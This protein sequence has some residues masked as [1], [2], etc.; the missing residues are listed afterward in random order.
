MKTLFVAILLAFVGALLIAG[1][2]K[3]QPLEAQLM[4]LQL[5]QTL[6][7]AADELA[8]EQ[9]EIQALF[10]AYA[11]DP[12]LSAKARLALLRHPDMAR[13]VFLTYGASPAFQDVL[14]RYGEDVV[15][16]IHY[17]LDNEV[18]T[19][20]LMRG[21]SDSARSA[22][23]AVRRLWDETESGS[24]LAA[25]PIT[26]EERGSYAIQFLSLEGYDF[27]GQFVLNQAGEVRW[28]QTE[29]VLEGLNSFFAGGIK[30]LETRLRREEEVGLGDVG[31]A[32]MDV[33]VGVTAFKLLRMGRGAA[34]GAG[35]LTYSQ[36]SAALGAG[37]WRTSVVG[38]R[39]AKYGAPAVLAYIAV[40]HPSVINSMLGAI[41]E[42]FDLPLHLVQVVGWT[43][44]LLPVM[45]LLRLLLGPLIWVLG[46]L[47]RLLGGLDR[48][49]RKRR[50][51]SAAMWS[52]NVR[53]GARE[54]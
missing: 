32:A 51:N 36:R 41:A 52:H 12:V 16:P 30:G 42:K 5:E 34:A 37:L 11:A 26:A 54:G 13:T 20:E 43:L 25:G 44:V 1:L 38:A 53:V 45:L 39:L 3:P 48:L 23:S 9:A 18:F 2:Y 31:W 19:L 4:H 22:L 15:L 21:L 27:L 8:G 40:R 35:T 10:L 7:E 29:R 33:A 50:A 49:W 14:A 24:A 46:G 47:V 28:V 6:P 17:F